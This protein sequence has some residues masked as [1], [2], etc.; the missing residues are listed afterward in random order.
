MIAR[1]L[2]FSACICTVTF[3]A[4]GSAFAEGSRIWSL[5]ALFKGTRVDRIAFDMHKGRNPGIVGRV[6]SEPGA[7][8]MPLLWVSLTTEQ[9][10][11]IAQSHH[12]TSG[13][14]FLPD[15]R[16]LTLDET[17]LYLL[18]TNAQLAPPAQKLV[19]GTDTVVREPVE[20]IH[21]WKGPRELRREF[22][23][24][25]TNQHGEVF[26]RAWVVDPHDPDTQPAGMWQQK[27]MFDEVYKTS[28]ADGWKLKQI[29][30]GGRG[31]FGSSNETLRG[32]ESHFD[33]YEKPSDSLVA[34]ADGGFAVTY[35]DPG[36]YGYVYKGTPRTD[37]AFD[38]RRITMHVTDQ[39]GATPEQISQSDYGRDEDLTA[40]YVT[41]E[42]GGNLLVVGFTY[43]DEG[44]ALE[45]E[46]QRI[47]R[48][49]PNGSKVQIIAGS[50]HCSDPNAKP[51]SGDPLCFLKPH[52]VAITPVP[53]GGFVLFHSLN[54]QRFFHLVGPPQSDHKLSEKVAAAE[55]AFIRGDH[56]EWRRH[57]KDLQHVR[58]LADKLTATLPLGKDEEPSRRVERSLNKLAPQTTPGLSGI[59]RDYPMQTRFDNCGRDK[60]GNRTGLPKKAIDSIED[61]ARPDYEKEWMWALRA[62]LAHRV[63]YRNIEEVD[64]VQL[65]E[66]SEQNKYEQGR[67][68]H[69]IE[70][71]ALKKIAEALKFTGAG[72]LRAFSDYY[73]VDSSRPRNLRQVRLNEELKNTDEAMK[74]ITR[75]VAGI[76]QHEALRVKSSNDFY[77]TSSSKR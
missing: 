53:G 67:P 26:L 42:A 75:L 45:T 62:T 6:A 55:R 77:H 1:G 13:F 21:E 46:P 70:E 64:R 14:A 11:V 76:Y 52:N 17:G 31:S 34:T 32:L 58:K 51:T 44:L 27:V 69:D 36:S 41:E 16:L 65:L 10:V 59:T 33:T 74:T 37:G 7:P 56:R 43:S 68:S 35:T 60:K 19:D 25:S 54:N 63:L 50:S 15:G 71:D 30:G 47:A 20:S 5:P 48:V 28:A 39:V 3:A 12:N 4:T 29:A 38:I 57:S 40:D 9:R 66:V 2:A 61:K 72:A 8:K 18:D 22:V 73:N 24:V 49:T 23:A